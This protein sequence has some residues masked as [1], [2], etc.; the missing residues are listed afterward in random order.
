MPRCLVAKRWLTELHKSIISAT[1][2]RKHLITRHL[3]TRHPDTSPP[4]THPFLETAIVKKYF[5]ST[6]ALAV[7]L[8]GAVAGHAQNSKPVLVISI[9]SYNDLM[10]NVNFFGQIGRSAECFAAD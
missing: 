5:R 7:L 4:D 2:V 8:V 10:A 6:L 9:P 3:D 1:C